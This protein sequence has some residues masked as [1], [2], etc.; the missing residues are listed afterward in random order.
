MA[1]EVTVH[2]L[3]SHMKESVRERSL[4]ALQTSPPSTAEVRSHSKGL[5]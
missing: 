5:T 2:S 4:V 3:R 1:Y